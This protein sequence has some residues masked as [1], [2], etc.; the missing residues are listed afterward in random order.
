MISIYYKMSL[1][2][3][4]CMLELDIKRRENER[5]EFLKEHNR[6]LSY[7]KSMLKVMNN[8][9]NKQ[10]QELNKLQKVEEN[11]LQKDEENK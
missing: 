1:K 2:S 7:S 3:K 6:Q 8:V 11:K 9:I 10:K 5:D 4:L